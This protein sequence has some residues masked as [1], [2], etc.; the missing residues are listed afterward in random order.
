MKRVDLK[1]E[2]AR[3]AWGY[4]WQWVKEN[5]RDL[6][7]EKY[8]TTKLAK[9]LDCTPGAVSSWKL[10]RAN[11]ESQKF[12][13]VVRI[14]NEWCKLLPPEGWISPYHY[15]DDRKVQ[16]TFDYIVDLTGR[17]FVDCDTRCDCGKTTPSE[18]KYCMH[19]GSDLQKDQNNKGNSE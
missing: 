1:Q 3:K 6:Y 13:E 10:G 11:F 14:L 19:C 12:A 16:H 18:G 4:L 2:A 5:E 17:V 9:R 8:V 15:F 7:K